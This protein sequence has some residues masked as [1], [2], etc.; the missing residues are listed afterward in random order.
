MLRIQGRFGKD[1]ILE[2]DKYELPYLSILKQ[3][4]DKRYIFRIIIVSNNFATFFT[5]Y[6]IR[7]GYRT[8]KNIFI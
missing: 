4:I 6:G 1:T 8:I 5:I 2:N 3:S 7:S